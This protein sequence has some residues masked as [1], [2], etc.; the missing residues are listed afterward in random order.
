MI[1]RVYGRHIT[2]NM[3]AKAALA[4]RDFSVKNS[5]Q[6]HKKCDEQ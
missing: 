1:S 5:R 3:E 2:A 6:I 4:L